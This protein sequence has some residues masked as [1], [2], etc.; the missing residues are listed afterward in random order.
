[1]GLVLSKSKEGVLVKEVLAGAV[2]EHNNALPPGSPD[3][4]RPGTPIL[5]V[6]KVEGAAMMKEVEKTKERTVE[7]EVKV[8]RVPSFLMWLENKDGK[9][10]N[11]EKLL[12]SPGSAHF[13]AN[14]LFLAKIGGAAWLISGY[15]IASLPSYMMISTAVSMYVSRCCHNEQVQS[16]EPHCYKGRKDSMMVVVTEAW[17]HLKTLGQKV[18]NDPKSYFDWLF[19]P[20]KKA[21]S[22]LF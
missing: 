5:K 1:M 10:N 15:P 22:F 9:P 13:A 4:I 17:S 16:G 18:S 19:I 6:D 21:Y 2:Q 20:D 14:W 12:T 3:F 7:L 8:N 11:I